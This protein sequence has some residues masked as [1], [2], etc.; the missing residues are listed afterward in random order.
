MSKRKTVTRA[1]AIRLGLTRYRTNRLCRNGH[2]ADRFTLNGGCVRCTQEA[3]RAWKE[4]N[5]ERVR[6]SNREATRRHR[7][8]VRLLRRAAQI[9][10]PG[11]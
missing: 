5:R 8:K 1:E 2:R 4:R 10:A 3:S 11:K 7:A 6:E 9:G